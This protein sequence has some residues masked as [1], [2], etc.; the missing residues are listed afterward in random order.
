MNGLFLRNF[1]A[2]QGAMA[3][4]LEADGSAAAPMQTLS[5]SELQERLARAR[6]DG[7][8]E[9][10][11]AGE[12]DTR[13][14]MAESESAKAQELRASILT[15]LEALSHEDAVRRL[16]ME[17]DTADLLL[18]LAERILPDFID[19]HASDLI[20]ERVFSGLKLAGEGALITISVAAENVA[21]IRE[22]A[23]TWTKSSFQQPKIEIES[24]P[25]LS[26][27]SV[28]IDWQNGY[29]DYDINRVSAA[30][31]KILRRAVSKM[32]EHL[33]KAK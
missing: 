3:Q 15:Q 2:D 28:R 33:K 12:L 18:A 26:Q 31:I 20:A 13:K 10:R 16:E 1:E 19:N 30:T 25:T 23:V 22:D 4:Q 27:T 5:E 11:L 29:L 32:N 17:R 9:G 14:A 8:A 21:R 24:D 7:F 6:L